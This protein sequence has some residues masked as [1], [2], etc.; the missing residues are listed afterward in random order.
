[1]QSDTHLAINETTESTTARLLDSAAFAVRRTMVNA[2]P[3]EVALKKKFFG[4][5]NGLAIYL[6][7]AIAALIIGPLAHVAVRA[8]IAE[9]F[10]LLKPKTE[11]HAVPIAHPPIQPVQIPLPPIQPN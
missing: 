1:M 7:I 4:M 2:P 9:I 10:G 5:E 6:G 8:K 11:V 3:P